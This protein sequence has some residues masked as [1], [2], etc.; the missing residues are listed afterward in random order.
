MKIVCAFNQGIGFGKVINQPGGIQFY[1]GALAKVPRILFSDRVIPVFMYSKSPSR[2]PVIFRIINNI[3]RPV[4]R[5]GCLVQVII[6]SLG[7][8]RIIDINQIST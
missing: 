8:V 1:P 7:F 2:Y 6:H 3:F 4:G 5:I